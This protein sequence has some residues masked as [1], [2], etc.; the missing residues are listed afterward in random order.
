MIQAYCSCGARIPAE[1][2]AEGGEYVEMGFKA[3][4]IRFTMNERG[5]QGGRGC[6]R[7]HGDKMKLW[8]TATRHGKWDVERIWDLKKAVKVAR[9]LEKLGVAGG[10]ASPCGLR[11]SAL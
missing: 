1:E 3:M 2:R 7:G 5:Y 9:E 11:Q 6:P 8:W 4:K 10:A